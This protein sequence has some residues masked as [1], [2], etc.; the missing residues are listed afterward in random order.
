M[1]NPLSASMIVDEL[2]HVY[3]LAE[4]TCV[5]NMRSGRAVPGYEVGLLPYSILI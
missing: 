2:G 5:W 3:Q 4:W 1:G